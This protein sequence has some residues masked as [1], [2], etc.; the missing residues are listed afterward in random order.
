MTKT[1]RPLIVLMCTGLL[2]AGP[3]RAAEPAQPRVTTIDLSAEAARPAENDLAVATAYFEATDAS[4]AAVARQV[5]RAIAAALDTAKAYGTVKTQSA[6][7]HTW[8]IYG[9]NDRK[10]E[11]WRMRSEIRLESRD[12]AALSELLGKLQATLAVSQI[13][14]EPAPETRRKAVEEA[15]VEAIRAFEQRAELIAGTFGK[16]YRIRHLNVGD[17]GYRP[18]I[19]RMQSVAM[20][21]K[22]SMPAPIEAGESQVGVAISGTIELSE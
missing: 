12:V 14:M 7:T 3:L 8:P 4:S 13:N 6:G 5:N 11:G 15:T 19:M 17:S 10:I 2:A 22:D 16:T 20:A 9:K 21:A 18:P 1:L